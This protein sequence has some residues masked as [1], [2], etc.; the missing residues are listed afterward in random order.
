MSRVIARHVI[1]SFEKPIQFPEL[2]N[3]HT[4]ANITSE[5]RFN[6]LTLIY[7]QLAIDISKK[8]DLVNTV[9][10]GHD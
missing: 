5:Q 9:F 2:G 1:S 6:I 8:Q 3:Q 10:I 7:T 4:R